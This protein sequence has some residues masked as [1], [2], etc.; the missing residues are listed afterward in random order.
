MDIS[1]RRTLR[2][3]GAL[4]A[5]TGL[6]WLAQGA[7]TASAAPS[8][9]GT[10]PR[11]L[12]VRESANLSVAASPDGRTLAIDV[13]GG[14]WTLPV[15]GG[16]ARL[17]TPLDHDASR[18]RFSPDGAR[19]L[20]QSFRDG[21]Y[22][23]WTVAPDGGRAERLTS[24]PS[25][26]TEPCFSPDGRRIAFASDRGNRSRIWLMDLDGGG[27]VP[28]T[29]A[30]GAYAAPAWSPDGRRLAYLVDDTAIE[31][32]DLASGR[33]ERPVTG[34]AT[35]AAPGFAPDG[36]LTY[37]RPDGPAADLVV[38]GQ[39]VV[40]GE[41]LP[42]LPV[43]WLSAQ[44]FLYTA[45]GRVRRRRLTG[46]ARE[47]AFTAALPLAARRYRR[48]PRD[49]GATAVRQAKGIAS[50]VLSRDGRQVAF[51]A[52]NALW[53]LPVGGV[54]RKVVDDGYF[55][56]D[57][58]FTPDG[59]S[60]V[61][62]SDRAGTANLWRL[63]LATGESERLTDAPDAQLTPRVSPDGTKIAYQ[64][65]AGAV[66]VLD[67][68]SRTTAQVLPALYQPGRPSWSPDGRRLALAALRPYSRR[69]GA[70]HNQI[71]T[72][73]LA[74]GEP[75]Y[76]AVAPER[77][78]STRGD[79]GPLWTREG[80]VFGAESLA[81][82]VPA[83]PD[84]V[85]TGPPVRLTGEVTDSL[86][87]GGDRLLYLS[88]GR[89]RLTGLGGGP[90]RTVAAALPYRPAR[91]TEH[92]VLRAGAVW[93]G[94]AGGLRHEVDI[95]L[96]GD[97]IAA[98]VPTASRAAGGARVVDLSGLTVL[99]GLID[100]H[101][102]WH[103]RGRQWGDRQGRLWLAYGVTTSR[104]PGDPAYQ[105]VENRE[106]L[107]AGTRVG[108]RYLGSGEAI[109]GTRASYNCMRTT[110]SAAQLERE[111][112]RAVGLDYDLVKLYMRLPVPL[113]RRAVERAH[114]AGIPVTSHYLYP[115]AHSG[116]DGMEHPGG[117]HRL[118][119]SR[120]LSHN[121]YRM[122]ADAV[123]L[124]AATGM[125]VSSTT[126]FATGLLAE[127]RSLVEDERTRVLFPDWE[128][129]R[130]VAKADGAGGPHAELYHRI[131]AGMVDAL[132]RVHRAGGLVVAGTDAPLDDVGI[133][134][135]Q[136]L[137]ALVKHGF[138][139]REALLTATGD[140]A[141]ALGYGGVLGVV[142]PGAFADLV[143]VEGDPLSDIRSAAAVRTVFVRGVPHTVADLLA[144]FRSP[145][146]A[147][148]AAVT[149][150]PP[151]ASARVRAEHYWHRPG[152]APESCCH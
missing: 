13:A 135:H 71:L 69:T 73:D 114:A 121:R 142:A 141:R 85:I 10:A 90:P 54:P 53:V 146:R 28:V 55:A 63:D 25:Y 8:A 109:D 37:I 101:N 138:T 118:G 19:V 39:A 70:G 11:T 4:T 62:V 84:G 6:T 115:A 32:L 16:R 2:L 42:P 43:A 102:H 72:V 79:D 125:W 3:G 68:A 29:E 83:G 140:A 34:S 31:V 145:A 21:V 137:R 20:F 128:Y 89:L 44:E 112:D 124:L 77:S 33:R 134:I 48:A 143:A 60:L 75:R 144:P 30:D 130:L 24:G 147:A 23:V 136:N 120:T 108:P 18:P 104:S 17:I 81:W 151:R 7:G 91:A 117:G 127:D 51:R 93:D 86:S 40:T 47:I 123:E 92:V 107:E 97:R 100:T 64:D 80:F 67:T 110:M 52:L 38:G 131:T 132:L 126:I 66:W 139:P 14:I 95:V 133:S 76:Q 45:G 27:P 122:S 59:R 149:A 103:M 99:P 49:L 50:P 58:D 65:E 148:A 5:G 150:G 87:V 105:M 78:L 88:N 129:E 116:L 46:P 82:R 74:G 22:D 56:S 111:L 1:R 41:D 106:A 98:V 36:R 9:A 113:E 26:D 57:P 35:L 94:R 96:K 61:Y 15:S 12:T 119:Y 152:W